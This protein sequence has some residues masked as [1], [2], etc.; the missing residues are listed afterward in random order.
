MVPVTPVN[1]MEPQKPAVEPEPLPPISH[2]RCIHP[3]ART[4]TEIVIAPPLE[5][6]VRRDA[7]QHQSFGM[8]TEVHV[9]ARAKLAAVQQGTTH[10]VAA[11]FQIGQII[12][13]VVL[14]GPKQQL[15]LARS[16]QGTASEQ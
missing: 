11:V 5:A 6:M 4:G 3:G 14:K 2:E 12:V 9:V 10:A 15:A 16:A 13:V 7:A 8:D 1:A